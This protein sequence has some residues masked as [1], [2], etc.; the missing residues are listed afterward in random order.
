MYSIE[1]LDAKNI[2]KAKGV[3]TCVTNKNIRHEN[4]KETL[5][6]GK[7]QWHEMKVL[8]SEGHEIYSMHMKKVSLSA[9][10][11]K[12]WIAEDVITTRAYGY[13]EAPLAR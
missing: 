4:Y 9:F 2:R 6:G 10:D 8:R 12:R 11:N 5:F 1:K 13:R 7:Q 3:K